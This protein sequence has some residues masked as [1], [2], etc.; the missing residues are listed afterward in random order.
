[1][2]PLLTSELLR[3][4]SAAL[5]GAA[6]HVV[7]LGIVGTFSDLFTASEEKLGIGLV[8]YALL[9]L[10][11]GVYQVGSYR[12]LGSFSYLIHRPLA[13]ARILLALTGAAALLL[14]FVAGL[15][16]L[17]AAIVVPTD[18]RNL[19]VA[20]LVLG[21]CLCFHLIGVFLVLNPSRARFAALL[22]P[23]AFLY[24]QLSPAA[25][26]LAIFGTLFWLWILASAA[27]KPD[28]STH[29]DRPLPI[30]AL[31][32][33]VQA[34]LLPALS[35]SLLSVYS[36]GVA[37]SEVGW[38]NIPA[39]GWNDYF[40]ED[41]FQRVEY[42][43]A[44]EALSSG[45]HRA[46]LPEAF[47]AESA[48]ELSARRLEAQRRGQLLVHDRH[49][50]LADDAHGLLFTFSHDLMLFTG[51]VTRTGQP[52]GWLGPAGRA[53]TIL[54]RARFEEVP[55]VVD[56]RFL[57]SPRR[58]H[59]V[60]ARLT[61]TQRFEA[62][63]GET[64]VAAL[65]PE[66]GTEPTA[67]LTDHALHLLAPRGVAIPFEGDVRNLS[68]A[69][70]ARYEDETLV[71]FVFGKESER[72][73]AV[74]RQTLGRVD[75][76]GRY[77]QLADLP[78]RQGPPAWTRHRNFLVAPLLT[79]ASEAA[80]R[81]PLSRPPASLWVVA[82]LVALISSALTLLVARRRQLPSAWAWSAAAL[83]TGFPGFLTFLLLTPRT[84]N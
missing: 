81:K 82:I 34:A 21:I 9:G 45:L 26:F 51:R 2:K 70:A 5:A 10:L 8:C 64:I 63:A 17:L 53:E 6:A 12:R 69:I 33:P 48:F 62:P 47:D 55:E 36:F 59:A 11:L 52:A 78:L 66:T 41:T 43:E 67:I 46:G 68:R 54:P 74:A 29:L 30:A 37:I 22:I 27:F 35:L 28:L 65:L 32:L 20:P 61:V 44:R 77:R 50:A 3:F 71:S 60:S 1:M 4:R 39:F 73:G 15:P 84:Q 40:P 58:I 18:A 23:A 13:P 25:T 7:I 14:T 16:L 38:R 57:V 80:L 56:G 42:L 79:F 72:D 49:Q 76:E 75:C 24:P 31:A 83:L 19:L